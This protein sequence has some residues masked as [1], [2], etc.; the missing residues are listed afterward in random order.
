MFL[1]LKGWGTFY[2]TTAANDSKGTFTVATLLYSNDHVL[3][4]IAQVFEYW[5][6]AVVYFN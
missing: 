1:Q 6:Q 3:D 5:G 2:K 4:N